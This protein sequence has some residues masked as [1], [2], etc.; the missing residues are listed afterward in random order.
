MSSSDAL[1]S[2]DASL[3]GSQKQAWRL[4]EEQRMQHSGAG[5]AAA[6][7]QQLQHVVLRCRVFHR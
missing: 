6:L 4:R 3:R 2:S 1:S 7:P 5:A